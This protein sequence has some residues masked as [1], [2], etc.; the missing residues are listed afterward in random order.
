MPTHKKSHDHFLLLACL[1]HTHTHTHAHAGPL[2][3]QNTSHGG[4]IGALLKMAVE[5][6]RLLLLLLPRPAVGVVRQTEC[7][8]CCCCCCRDLI[9]CVR[10]PR[11]MATA[12]K[13]AR[14]HAH[15]VYTD[16]ELAWSDVCMYVY[17]GGKKN[18]IWRHLLFGI[19]GYLSVY[20]E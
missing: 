10:L 4:T 6:R 8:C 5:S 18:S 19:Y 15:Y 2:T 12:G 20:R 13:W 17:R 11:A 16:V 7:S 14:T 9:F 3:V 1:S